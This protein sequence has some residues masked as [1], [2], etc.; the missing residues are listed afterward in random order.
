MGTN[1]DKATV[2]LFSQLDQKR[3]DQWGEVVYSI[4]FLHSTRKSWSTINKL[5]GRFGD[6]FRL[7]PVSTNSIASQPVKN[8]T[9]GECRGG[10]EGSI[11]ARGH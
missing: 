10:G 6:S 5:T 1:C 2:S 3:Q 8:V 7:Y 11:K 4:D 9:P